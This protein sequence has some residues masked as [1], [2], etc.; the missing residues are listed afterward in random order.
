[1]ILRQWSAGWHR[2]PALG[3]VGTSNEAFKM[4]PIPFDIWEGVHFLP[5]AG[6]GARS[7]LPLDSS[8]PS[9]TNWHLPRWFRGQRI[10]L[11][12][13][14]AGFDAWVRKMP[15]GSKEPTPVFLPGESYGQRILVG[16]SPWSHIESGMTEQLAH[17]IEV[18]SFLYLEVK[19]PLLR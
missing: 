4:T 1:M 10:H 12:C 3:A 13:S 18:V 16:Y 5:W 2:A 11:Q 8:S 6:K 15:C 14:R 7:N 9:T 17:T 19:L